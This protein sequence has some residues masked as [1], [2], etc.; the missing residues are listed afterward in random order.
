MGEEN[1]T[2]KNGDLEEL[3]GP[4]EKNRTPTLLPNEFDDVSDELLN[5]SDIPVND[6]SLNAERVHIDYTLNP[7]NLKVPRMRMSQPEYKLAKLPISQRHQK[8]VPI[9][10]KQNP[11]MH[12]NGKALLTIHGS[13]SA[14]SLSA[15]EPRYA[16]RVVFDERLET[17]WPPN[18]PMTDHYEIIKWNR[19]WTVNQTHDL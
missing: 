13:L 19:K 3:T 14:G 6:G 1:I 9:L 4:T 5:V 2:K 17:H 15:T 11:P 10:G 12:G 18:F 8:K 16:T 7:A